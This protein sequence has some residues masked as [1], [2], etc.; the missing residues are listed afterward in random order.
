MQSLRAPTLL[1]GC[2]DTL[3]RAYAGPALCGVDSSLIKGLP[4]PWVELLFCQKADL[5]VIAFQHILRIIICSIYDTSMCLLAAMDTVGLVLAELLPLISSLSSDVRTHSLWDDKLACLLL[6]T[7]IQIRRLVGRAL[8]ALHV[9][10]VVALSAP[11]ACP[12]GQGL[13]VCRP[14]HI[15]LL[16]STSFGAQILHTCQL[17]QYR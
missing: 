7:H 9:C 6:V 11:F 10:V 12:L 13:Q 2:N 16:H 8:C 15:L 3:R 17:P 5:L 1:D 14:L 4:E